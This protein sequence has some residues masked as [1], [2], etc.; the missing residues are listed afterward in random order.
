M[1]PAVA[2]LSSPS[3]ASDTSSDVTPSKPRIR[4]AAALG[5]GP[6]R[7][8]SD[9]GLLDD[10]KRLD[11]DSKRTT[12]HAEWEEAA[13]VTVRKAKKLALSAG[14]KDMCDVQRAFTAAGIAMDKAYPTE[15][16]GGSVQ[17]FMLNL[18]QVGSS[19]KRYSATLSGSPTLCITK[20]LIENSA[21]DA[22]A[23]DITESALDTQRLSSGKIAPTPDVN[24]E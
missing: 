24:A 5:A 8:P 13:F 17:N 15:S 16:K 10:F 2:E 6:G 7:P 14:K 9:A 3:L 1:S 19:D 21:V 18:F 11:V 4:G 22:Q 23:V 20:P 12:V